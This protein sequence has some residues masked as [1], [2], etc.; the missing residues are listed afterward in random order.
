[1]QTGDVGVALCA[2]SCP[3]AAARSP[4]ETEKAGA[5]S[6]FLPGDA[7]LAGSRTQIHH[8]HE[9]R[10]NRQGI[11][12]LR[13]AWKAARTSSAAVLSPRSRQQLHWHV[14]ASGTLRSLS[15][16][17]RGPPRRKALR[18]DKELRHSQRRFCE[19]ISQRAVHF[20]SK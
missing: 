18:S 19:N 8:W 5:E 20:Y 7:A 11:A 9:G 6:R 10:G 3:C 1:M 16:L 13:R 4:A 12:L 2:P 14:P 15:P 17:P